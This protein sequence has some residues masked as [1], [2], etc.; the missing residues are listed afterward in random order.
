MSAHLHANVPATRN[1]SRREILAGAAAAAVLSTTPEVRAL[2]EEG[3][4][5]IHMFAFRWKPLATEEQKNRA[6]EE[7]ASFQGKVL[8]CKSTPADIRRAGKDMR[9]VAS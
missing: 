8:G 4:Q 5:M 7:I 3:A 9:P 1:V 6:I 2:S